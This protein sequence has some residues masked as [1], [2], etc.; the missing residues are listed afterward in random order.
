MT[1]RIFQID[2]KLAKISKKEFQLPSSSSNYELIYP[3]LGSFNQTVTEINRALTGG[4]HSRTLQYSNL[5]KLHRQKND[6]NRLK[7]S[8]SDRK[9]RIAKLASYSKNTTKNR[10]ITVSYNKVTASKNLDKE[11]LKLKVEYEKIIKEREEQIEKL[12]MQLNS[13][14]LSNNRDENNSESNISNNTKNTK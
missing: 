13:A 9:V 10:K 11:S 5:E 3:S 8:I 12:T 6:I 1:E 2:E 7:Q 4:F 14:S